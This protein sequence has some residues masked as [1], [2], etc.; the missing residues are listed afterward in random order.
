MAA[1]AARDEAAGP[2]D[3]TPAPPTK[4]QDDATKN[5]QIIVKRQ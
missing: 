4:V 2:G 5:L 3:R 1:H